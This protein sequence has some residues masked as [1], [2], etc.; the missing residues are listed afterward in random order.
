VT[1]APGKGMEH[2][3]FDHPNSTLPRV[4]KCRGFPYWVLAVVGGAGGG[5]GIWL[6]TRRPDGPVVDHPPPT[7]TTISAGTPR[8]GG[9]P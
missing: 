3:R 6:A 4:D 5:A 2:V 7:P 9:P 8:V 1:K